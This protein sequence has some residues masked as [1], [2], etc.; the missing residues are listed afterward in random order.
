MFDLGL[1]SKIVGVTDYC[2]Y[3][4][5]IGIDVVRVGGVKD[6]DVEII[7]DLSPD[8]V[9]ANQ[10][11]NSR[12]PV[13]ALIQ[14][15]IPVWVAFPK[16][17]RE[18]V[19]DLWSIAGLFQSEIS[20]TKVRMLEMALEWAELAA[21]DIPRRSFFCP[22]WQT[23]DDG[24]RSWMTFNRDTYCNDL[25][26]VVGGHNVFG[27]LETRY[28][29]VTFEE[30]HQAKPEV[31]LLPSEPFSFGIAEK[32]YFRKEFPETEIILV[33]GT[34][35]TWCGTRMGKALAELQKYFA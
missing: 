25:L 10:E 29:K 22:I 31:I 2:V 5:E 3:P 24:I 19:E 11:E 7:K 13:E 23:D 15:E 17:C 33:D 32:E 27:N 6:P 30:I 8:L 9:L 12:E 4:R 35:I 14:S 21:A 16:T 34:Y 28:S 20:G 26:A 1:G 18:V